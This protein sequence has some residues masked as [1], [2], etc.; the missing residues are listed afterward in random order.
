MSDTCA[1]DAIF[2][3]I[4]ARPGA[5]SRDAKMLFGSP[6]GRK[7]RDFFLLHFVGWWIFGPKW[8]GGC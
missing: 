7:V 5:A 6:R 2:Y 8:K 3:T 1:K 4:G